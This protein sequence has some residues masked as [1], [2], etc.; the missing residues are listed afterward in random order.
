MTNLENCKVVQSNRFIQQTVWSMDLIALKTFKVLV[1]AIDTKNA[2]TD[3]NVVYV[4]KH[5]LMVLTTQDKHLQNYTACTN[6]LEGLCD[7]KLRVPIYDPEKGEGT[8]YTH[9]LKFKNYT[10]S[11]MI[12]VEF[13]PEIMPFLVQLKQKFLSYPVTHIAELKTKYGLILYEYL[14]SS[15]KQYYSDQSHAKIK[16]SLEDLR[17]VTGTLDKKSYDVWGEFERRVLSPAVKDINKANVS[18]QILETNKFRKGRKI[19]SLVFLVH[20][21]DFKIPQ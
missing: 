4:N 7:V 6:V 3:D 19:D 20:Y 21:K 5:E 16:I 10:Y 18:I 15:Y 14:L 12:K 11:E 2:T 9:L 8:L 17:R 1:S 13:E